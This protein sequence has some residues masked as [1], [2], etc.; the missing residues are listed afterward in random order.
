VA[1]LRRKLLFNP[2][3]TE[4]VRELG[5]TEYADGQILEAFRIYRSAIESGRSDNSLV[6][7]LAQICENHGLV[8][9]TADLLDTLASHQPDD[10][11]IVAAR[12]KYLNL[13]SNERLFRDWRTGRFSSLIVDRDHSHDD[14]RHP[15][16]CDQALA[17]WNDVDPDSSADPVNLRRAAELYEQSIASNPDDIHAY[18]DAAAIYENLKSYD[19]AADLYRR[20]TQVTDD[21][22]FCKIQVERLRILR[23]L[24]DG[25]STESEKATLLLTLAQRCERVGRLEE[26]IQY[27]Q[28]SLSINPRQLEGW[29]TLAEVSSKVGLYSEAIDAAQQALLLDPNAKSAVEIKNRLEKLGASL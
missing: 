2:D 9:L 16:T 23:M 21:P 1:R 28:Q 14:L 12:D 10:V 22:S 6:S 17:L 7:D 20:A 8:K 4:L 15:E 27:S 29:I 26:S 3:S 25:V 19:K 5:R 18:V 24:E 11:A 13:A